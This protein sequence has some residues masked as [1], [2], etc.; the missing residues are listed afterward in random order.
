MGGWF[1]KQFPVSFM[2]NGNSTMFISLCSLDNYVACKVRWGYY[3]I[4]LIAGMWAAIEAPITYEVCT[5]IQFLHTKLVMRLLECW[6]KLRVLALFDIGVNEKKEWL[7]ICCSKE[8]VISRQNCC[9]TISN[10]PNIFCKLVKQFCIKDTLIE[11]S[12]LEARAQ[13]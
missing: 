3:M 5:V 12:V 8:D 2:R 4:F 13:N 9:F 7:T 11:S 10:T 1:E 6:R